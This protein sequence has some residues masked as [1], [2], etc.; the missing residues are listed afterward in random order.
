MV[1]CD[2]KKEKSMEYHTKPNGKKKEN[3]WGLVYCPRSPKSHCLPPVRLW[4]RK[5]E[6]QVSGRGRGKLQA[7]GLQ[8]SEA[9]RNKGTNSPTPSTSVKGDAPASQTI[10]F[11]QLQKKYNLVY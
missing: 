5:R 1:K 7:A 8:S 2:Q 4:A 9:P 3:S 10:S 11:K 6:W